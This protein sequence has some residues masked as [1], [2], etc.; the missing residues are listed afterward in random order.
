MLRKIAGTTLSRVLVA[1]CSFISLVLNANFLGANGLGSIG[2]LVLAIT[3]FILVYNFVGG[4]ALVY[5]VPKYSL[6]KLL[7]PSY[8]WSIVTLLLFFALSSLISIVPAYLRYHFLALAFIQSLTGSHINILAGQQRFFPFNLI[9]LL[10]AVFSLA[11]LCYFYFILQMHSLKAFIYSLY[12][13]NIISLLYSSFEVWR[14]NAAPAP[15]GNKSSLREMF[16][17]GFYM[18][19]ADIFQ[20]MNYRLSYYFVEFYSGI[21]RL[22]IFTAGVQLSESLWITSRSISTVQYA[23]ISN[24]NARRKAITLSLSLMKISFAITLILLLVLLTLP[25]RF[26]LFLLG[27]S[28]AGIK[29]VIW[30]LSPGILLFSAM[31]IL[32]HFFSGTGRQQRNT[33]SSALGAA[34]TLVFAW[35]LIP[36]MGITGAAITSSISIF[37]SF[38]Y[39]FLMMK[40]EPKVEWKSFLLNKKDVEKAKSIVREQLAR[41]HQKQ[42]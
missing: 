37:V 1:L 14:A 27:D 3:I 28:L 30:Y 22:G 39:L 34:A 11:A 23:G 10:R 12:F 24:M 32:A 36:G 35:L 41:I 31:T 7:L 16:R 13:A 15:L 8:A 25:E 5:L 21:A 4:A 38:L 33:V 9:N 2:L 40:K 6:K 26:Y 29:T 42:Q 20:L 19:F 18:Q 17:L